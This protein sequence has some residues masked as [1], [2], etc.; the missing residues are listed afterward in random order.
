MP[1]RR[2]SAAR[3]EIGEGGGRRPSPLPFTTASYTAAR[4]ARLPSSTSACASSARI[5]RSAGITGSIVSTSRPAR[6][7]GRQ[8][9]LHAAHGIA[10]AVEQ[11]VDPP[12]QTRHPRA[13][14]SAG[15]PRAAA[16][17]AAES[18]FPN[19]AGYA[20]ASPVSRDSSPIV[21][22]A[23][24]AL[25]GA[26][27]RIRHRDQPAPTMRSRIIWLARKVSTRRG[28]IGTS[29]PV[30][31]LRPTRSPLSR[32]TK[33]AEAR[34]LDVLAL[35]TA[36]RTSRARICSTSL[37]RIGARQPDLAVQRFGQIGPRQ[38]TRIVISHAPQLG[39][40]S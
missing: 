40:T 16:A 20:A 5:A 26:R 14:N 17:A 11:R 21:R 23:P 28:A 15:C 10:F 9:L 22:N 34:D 18:A 29:T 33:R 30:L 38:R 19:S 25:S 35:A 31:G 1:P 37:R 32:S 7:L 4:Y 3:I 12:H 13:G 39:K 8:Q 2:R 6:L 24:A 36:R 27:R